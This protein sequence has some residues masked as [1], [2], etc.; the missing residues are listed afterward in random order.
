MREE[1]MSETRLSAGAGK[2]EILFPEEMLPTD[3]FCKIHDYPHIRVLLLESSIR[4]VIV[5]IELAVVAKPF[6]ADI[7]QI[8]SELTQ[9]P[10]ENIWVHA[11]HVISTPHAPGPKQKGPP[12]KRPPMTEEDK[13]KRGLFTEAIQRAA[14]K[15][16]QGAMDTFRQSKVGFGSGQCGINRSN[17]GGMSNKTLSVLRFD[18]LN[19]EP[20][21]FLISY[22][23]K[24]IA[25][26]NSEMK[27][28]TRQIS[29]DV[30]GKACSLMEEELGAPVLFCMS[31]AGDQRPLEQAFYNDIDENGNTVTVDLGVE[32]G[33]E[34][35]RRYG[36]IMGNDAVVIAG[37]IACEET[38]PVIGIMDGSFQ[39]ESK[40]AEDGM[41]EVPVRTARIGDI[42]LVATMPEINCITEHELQEA[43]PFKHTL[44]MTM[45]DGP[46]KYMPDI[47]AYKMNTR[48][49]QTSFAA[50]GAA[51]KFVET[52]AAIL[53]AA[54]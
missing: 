50:P 40:K 27:G 48:E 11:T 54:Q 37:A 41:V 51:E 25:I 4:F 31:G 44:L 15:A 9:T 23:I 14:R 3:G 33:L 47:E 43:S 6:V 5:A 52:A 35:V 36:T 28:G 10:K 21:G 49:A 29:S 16:A 53:S 17:N 26:D 42:A 7:K 46:M 1:T 38:A 2:A 24:S 22:G 32:H 13:L 8:V 34:L 45:T 19:G 30:P 20:I 18:A 39:C 12:D